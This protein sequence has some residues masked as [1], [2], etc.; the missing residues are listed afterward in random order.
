MF[1]SV[2]IR[3]PIPAIVLAFV[4][5]S[6]VMAL[7][8]PETLGAHPW[9]ARQVILIGAPVGILLSLGLWALRLKRGVRLGVALLALIAAYLIARAGHMGF[10]ASYAEDRFAGQMWYFGWIATGAALAALATAFA[11]DRAPRPLPEAAIRP[12]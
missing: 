7:N 8:L 11:R 12:T 5:S 4:V 9:W 1:P 10:A 6:L 2:I 3:A